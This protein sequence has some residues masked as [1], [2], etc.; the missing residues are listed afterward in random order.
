LE[1]LNIL[2][3]PAAIISIDEQ[4]TVTT[5]NPA[6]ERIFGYLASEVFGRRGPQLRGRCL[7]AGIVREPQRLAG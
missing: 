4:G 7:A 1:D 6:A 2:A 3:W 5:F